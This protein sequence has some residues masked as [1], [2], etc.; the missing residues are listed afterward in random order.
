[1]HLKLHN[2]MQQD[3]DNL[4]YKLFVVSFAEFLSDGIH[5]QSNGFRSDFYR[6]RY[7]TLLWEYGIEKAKEGYVSPLRSNS[8]FSSS[9]RF[10]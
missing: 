3:C 2:I 7:T 9:R 1:M 10:G 5:V 4:G 6:T 8:Q